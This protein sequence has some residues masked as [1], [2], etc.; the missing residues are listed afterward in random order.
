MFAPL[1][2]NVCLLNNNSETGSLEM[3]CS[4]NFVYGSIIYINSALPD[5]DV[6]MKTL[7]HRILVL[8]L[9]EVVNVACQIPC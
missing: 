7:S 3:L 8:A 1:I 5:A 4:V 2:L 9:K 6:S